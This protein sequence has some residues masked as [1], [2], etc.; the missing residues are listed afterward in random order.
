MVATRH[1]D[2]PQPLRALKEISVSILAVEKEAKGLL[3]GLQNRS[4]K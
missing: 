1:F 2:K 4:P 3:D